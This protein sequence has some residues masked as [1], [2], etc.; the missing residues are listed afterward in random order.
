MFTDN[1]AHLS[2]IL[3]T[4]NGVI[5]Y[6]DGSTKTSCSSYPDEG[7]HV[8]RIPIETDS[9]VQHLIIATNASLLIL[10][11]VEVFAGNTVYFL[12]A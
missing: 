5:L 9:A 3:V 7:T 4:G 12:I 1:R 10:C 8:C 11:E 6:K 2:G